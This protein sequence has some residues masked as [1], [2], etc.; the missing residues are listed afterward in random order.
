[1][2]RK[3]G[4]AKV[5]KIDIALDPLEGNKPDRQGDGERLAVMG[6]LRRAAGCCLRGRLYGQKSPSD[7]G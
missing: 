4:T 1:M 7:R 2:A 6:G 3:V 5:Q